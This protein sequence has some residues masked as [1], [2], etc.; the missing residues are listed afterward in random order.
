MKVKNNRNNF[1]KLHFKD[2]TRDERWN[3]GP[4]E[5]VS[6]ANLH[7]LNQ[8][9]NKFLFTSKNLEFLLEDVKVI[10][11]KKPEEIKEIKA[12]ETTKKKDKTSKKD[13]KLAEIDKKVKD[14]ENSELKSADS[15]KNKTKKTK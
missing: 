5:T 9:V 11:E 15:K 8:V 12:K 4:K 3:I 10:V 14:Y 1:V 2:G 13:S 6:I 7:G